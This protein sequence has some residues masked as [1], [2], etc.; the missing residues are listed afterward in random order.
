MT[1]IIF[2]DNFSVAPNATVENV[3]AGNTAASRYIRPPYNAIGKLFLAVTTLSVPGLRL[4]L[5]VDGKTILDSSDARQSATAALL[6]PDDL[7]VEQF[8]VRKGAQIVLRAVNATAGAISVTYRFELN[9]TDN[10]IAACR[11]TQRSVSLTANN[12]FQIIAGLRFERPLRNSLLTFLATASAG[13][14]L[15]ELFVDGVS[16]APA[17]P[18]GSTN[19]MPLNP[20]DTLISDVEAPMDKLIEVRVQNTTG[21][22]LTLFW[23]THLQELEVEGG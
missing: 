5:V 23:R 22:A 4:E 2:Q 12:T 7:V 20:Y 21:G 8:T 14:L 3:I 10:A 9:E 18:V 6:M 1:P 13:G 19:R 17:M 16:V 15:A 11:Y